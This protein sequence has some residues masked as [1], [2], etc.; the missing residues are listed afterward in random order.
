MFLKLPFS[1]LE[2]QGN[3]LIQ[4]ASLA[5]LAKITTNCPEHILFESLDQITDKLL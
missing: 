4:M 3:K 1:L 2:K 5:S